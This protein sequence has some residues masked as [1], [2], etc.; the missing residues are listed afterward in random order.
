V[1]LL[2]KYVAIYICSEM[3]IDTEWM[4]YFIGVWL[5]HQFGVINNKKINF[6]LFCM[7]VMIIL[8]PV[9]WNL[10]SRCCI[11][12]CIVTFY[13]LNTKVL[14]HFVWKALCVVI[15]LKLICNEKYVP[16]NN[17]FGKWTTLIWHVQTTLFKCS[18]SIYV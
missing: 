4:W 6:S 9:C 10:S 18:F 12:G 3:F 1:P 5:Q 14:K 17:K 2:P 16:V 7:S 11:C 8:M 15:V 13:F